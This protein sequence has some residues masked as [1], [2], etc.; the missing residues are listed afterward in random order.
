MRRRVESFRFEGGLLGRRISGD[1][2]FRRSQDHFQ[3]VF[4][5][6][7]VSSL[8]ELKVTQASES[9]VSVST[10][11]PD[12]RIEQA[13]NALSNGKTIGLDNIAAEI[14]KECA[15]KLGEILE[16]VCRS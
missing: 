5:A 9:P 13:L 10:R 4:G 16:K 14:L 3:G 15:Q 7:L 6:S 12:E 2:Y 11:P 1:E 8:H